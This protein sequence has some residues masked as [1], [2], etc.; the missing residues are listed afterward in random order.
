MTSQPRGRTRRLALVTALLLGAACRSAVPP[1]VVTRLDAAGLEARLASGKGRLRVLNFWATWCVPC[2]QEMPL[3]ARVA[4]DH[5][6]PDLEMLGIS[7]DPLVGG[8]LE[9]I[10]ASVRAF[11]T[12]QGLGFEQILFTGNEDD[13]ARLFD[14]PGSL[15][16]TLV[17]GA[18][19]TRLWAHEGV[20]APGQLDAALEPLLASLP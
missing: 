13:L 4:R 3:L 5:V 11:A 14:H 20:L 18:D 16:Y 6:G 1:T 7:C 10:E 12:R 2:V 15:P 9:K 17:L 19:G 8:E